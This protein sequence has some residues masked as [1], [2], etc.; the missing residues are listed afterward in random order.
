MARIPDRPDRID[1]HMPVLADSVVCR[2]PLQLG[3][4]IPDLAKWC[5]ET[6]EMMERLWTEFAYHPGGPG[7]EL[8]R[9]DF[10]QCAAKL[11]GKK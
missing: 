1:F 10:E 7:Y 2:G 3:D 4:N 8:A 5:Q 11:C 9:Q 6:R